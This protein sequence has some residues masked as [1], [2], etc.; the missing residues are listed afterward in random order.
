MLD[1]VKEIQGSVDQ[2]GRPSANQR[3]KKGTKRSSKL[4]VIEE[5]EEEVELGEDEESDEVSGRDESSIHEVKDR[6]ESSIHEE[7][8]DHNETNNPCPTNLQEREAQQPEDKTSLES[9]DP[10]KDELSKLPLEPT[11]PQPADSESDSFY[12]EPEY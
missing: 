8:K 9:E 2:L 5:E 7:A 1:V 10:K 12:D 3:K 6:N 11:L 4:E